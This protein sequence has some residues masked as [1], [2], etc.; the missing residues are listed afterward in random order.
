M[1]GMGEVCTRF[2]WGNLS[3]GDHWGDPGLDGRIILGWILGKWVCGLDGASSGQEQVAC[4]CECGDELSD[5]IKWGNFFTS[6]RPV[7]FPRRI[8]LHGVSK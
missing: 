6:C 3:E 5:S 2:W 1:W 8:L 7:S 4:A